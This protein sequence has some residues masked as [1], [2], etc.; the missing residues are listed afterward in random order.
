MTDASNGSWEQ[1]ID[2]KGAPETSERP[3]RIPALPAVVAAKP[4]VATTEFWMSVILIFLH[5]LFIGAV[6]AAAFTGKMPIAQ[7]I[8]ISQ[9]VLLTAGGVVAA[10]G[11]G[12]AWVKKTEMQNIFRGGDQ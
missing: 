9:S 7:A 5:A 1:I 11:T 4:G 12:R 2:K 8:D 6:W 3:T 10:Y